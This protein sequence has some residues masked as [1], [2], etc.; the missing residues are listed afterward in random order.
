MS[1]GSSSSSEF[2]GPI[3]ISSDH[4]R[5]AKAHGL[6][7]SLYSGMYAEFTGMEGPIDDTDPKDN[8]ALDFVKLLWPSALIAIETNWYAAH[9]ATSDWSEASNNEIYSFL[10]VIILMGLYRLPR[11]YNYWNTKEYYQHSRST[12]LSLDS[13]TCGVSK[14]RAL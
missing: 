14:L 4:K 8:S 2:E 9:K 12:C 7:Q 13:G 6:L 11:I 5:E 10:G 3:C 1:T